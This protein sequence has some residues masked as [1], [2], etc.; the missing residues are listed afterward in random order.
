MYKGK[1]A[2]LIM[3]MAAIFVFPGAL[4]AAEKGEKS[5]KDAILQEL[6]SFIDRN[7]NILRN[8]IFS[9]GDE[10]SREN[11]IDE[12]IALYEKAVKLSPKDE[13]LLNRL[14]GLYNQKRDYAKA[15]EVYKK[16]TEINPANV[17]YFNM[18][19]DAYR[20]AGEKEKAS[21]VWDELAKKSSD[22][23][24]FIQAANFYSSE[25]DMEKAIAAVK[26]ASELE[27]KNVSYLQNLE[28]F[29]MRLEKFTEA[30][31]VCKK[32]LELSVDP[33]MKDWVAMELINIYQRQDK[34]GELAARFEKELAQ[35]PKELGNYKKLAELYQ[36]NNE[37]DKA[38][39]LYEKA[40]TDGIADRDIHDRLLNLYEQS[41]DVDKA[42]KLVEKMIG[43]SPGD[44]Y[45]YE[46]LANLLARAGKTDEAKKTWS[47][48]LKKTSGDAGA[49]SRFGDRLNEW[50]ETDSAI[51]QYK[52]AQSLDVNNLWYTMRIAD[53]LIS[54][55]KFDA[56][57]KELNNIIAKSADTWIKQEAERKISDINARMGTVK[58][59]PFIPAP[60]PTEPEKREVKEKI[61]PVVEPA[62]EKKTE[63]APEQ[64]P[65]KK[66]KG[67][68]GR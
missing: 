52:K 37:R 56:A 67:W 34:L 5:D 28:S 59:A 13:D 54:K 27:P 49:F 31:A 40:S 66:R 60:T 38:I 16:M 55:E 14:G 68:F 62:A 21:G 2:V 8:V 65:E 63:Q 7:P 29:Y 9:M 19:S 10:Y 15:A 47:E 36:R 35:A 39:G 12:A 51:E 41:E 1:Y 46:R 57:E 32:V 6:G 23:N 11:K 33:W 42:K 61:A 25:N 20:N 22:A 26:K 3:L 53:I 45:L 24:V 30:E 44:T 17:W 50:G 58:E 64:K 43:I 4:F 18:L 48:F